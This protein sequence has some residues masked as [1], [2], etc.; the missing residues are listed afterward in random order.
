DAVTTNISQGGRGD[1]SL[2]K[3]IPDNV[4]LRVERTALK[5]AKALDLNFSGTD[6]IV[7]HNL[8][9]T[10]VVDVNM[11]PGFPKRRTFN[12]ARRL[13]R[14]LKHRHGKKMLRFK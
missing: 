11:F 3:V 2:L 14:E 9:N 13:V 8:K 7:D 1:P 4:L 5:A 10:Y 12:L 6:V